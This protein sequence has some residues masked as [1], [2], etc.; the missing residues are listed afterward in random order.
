M[1]AAD[2]EG[3]TLLAASRLN[4]LLFWRARRDRSIVCDSVFDVANVGVDG[5][6]W[7]TAD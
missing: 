7:G 5:W 6:S 2:V 1:P 3:L 4:R